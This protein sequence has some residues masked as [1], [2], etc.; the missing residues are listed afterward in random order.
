MAGGRQRWRTLISAAPCLPR[1]AARPSSLYEAAEEGPSA[2]VRRPR[3]RAQRG[4]LTLAGS[5]Y[6]LASP[7]A[8]LAKWSTPRV[9]LSGA[10]SPLDL[11]EQPHFLNTVTGA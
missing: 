1:P 11:F 9:R 10:A 2:G 5:V 3:S 6:P 7:P 8:Q 4:S